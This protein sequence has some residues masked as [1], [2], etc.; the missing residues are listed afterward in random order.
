M[1]GI[2]LADAN[3]EAAC[4]AETELE[5]AILANVIFKDADL[6]DADMSG[7]ILDGADLSG[8]NL[9]RAN[10]RGASFTDARL[11]AMTLTVGRAI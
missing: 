5:F 11:C 9:R 6:H 2:N 4:L 10:L 8:A 3:C 1:S 7:V